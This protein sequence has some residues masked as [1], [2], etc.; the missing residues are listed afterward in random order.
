MTITNNIFP[1][2]QPREPIGFRYQSLSIEYWNGIIPIL[3]IV[4]SYN[5]LLRG[6]SQNDIRSLT[7][8][9]NF[10]MVCIDHA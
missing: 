4:A 1:R 5:L 8:K 2:K 10:M 6:N 9:L 3:P 7:N